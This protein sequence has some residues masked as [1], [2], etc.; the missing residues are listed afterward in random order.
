MG[1]KNVINVWEPSP[2]RKCPDPPCRSN[3]EMIPYLS[4]PMW[5][6]PKNN[7]GLLFS[8]NFSWS[9][10]GN[11]SSQ[12]LLRWMSEGLGIKKNLSQL[13]LFLA[14]FGHN[15]PDRILWSPYLQ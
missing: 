3:P 8:E 2:F 5:P 1:C 4:P 14:V 10:A 7:K 11:R 12:I 6:K 13:L 15:D 9:R